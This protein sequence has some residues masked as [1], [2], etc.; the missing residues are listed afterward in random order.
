VDEPKLQVM[1]AMVEHQIEN[2]SEPFFATARLW[3][4]GILDPRDTRDVIGICL[5]AAHAR[6]VAGTTSWGV[7][8]H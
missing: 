8:R 5:S 7:F 1:K 3:D 4:D 6:E 2:E